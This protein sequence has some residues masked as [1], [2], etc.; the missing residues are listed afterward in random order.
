MPRLQLRHEIL[1][2][3]KTSLEEI[4]AQA[5][6]RVESWRHPKSTANYWRLRNET[7]T[8]KQVNDIKTFGWD[9]EE[10]SATSTKVSTLTTAYAINSFAA[11]EY[12]QLSHKYSTIEFPAL[13]RCYDVPEHATKQNAAF[14]LL[15]FEFSNVCR[16]AAGT[17]KWN[18]VQWQRRR[19]RTCRRSGHE[20][21]W[22]LAD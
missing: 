21:R 19:Q 13:Q 1:P 16:T 2:L 9:R 18:G 15:Q 20:F 4:R 10:P 7:R 17:T 22:E 5:R 6:H 3:A 14:S 11:Y 12:H 8:E